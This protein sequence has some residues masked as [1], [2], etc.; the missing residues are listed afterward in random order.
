MK[1]HPASIL[2]V[3]DDEDILLTLKFYLRQYFEHIYTETNP[4]A[5]PRW[6]RKTDLDVILLD[7]NFRKGITSGEEGMAWLQKTKQLAPTVNIIMIT[8]HGEIEMAV[9]AVKHGAFDFIIKP[10]RNEK[11]RTTILA[12]LQ[13]NKSQK[14]LNQLE[15]EQKFLRKD[16]DQQWEKMIGSSEA[17]QHIHR[18]ID[19]VAGTDANI[20]ILG[21]NGT[22]KE[23]V[24]R[25]IH[26]QSDRTTQAFINV[27]LGAIQETLFES[28]LFGHIKGSFTDAKE[29]RVGRFE[30]ASGGTLFLDEIGNLSLPLQAKLLTAL[31]TR[32]I[33]RVGSNQLIYTNIRLISATNAPLYQMVKDNQFR[34]DLLYRINTVEIQLPPLR[35]RSDDIPDLIDYFM[36][37]F[38]KKYN[39]PNIKIN[40]PVY[41]KLKSYHWPGNIRELSHAVERAIIMTENGNLSIDDFL[42]R[43]SNS[44]STTTN[45][46]DT[47]NLNLEAVEK[48]TIELAL[49]AEQGNISKAAKV[50]GLTRGALYRRMEKYGL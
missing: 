14:K 2:L 36:A 25:A 47:K 1:K 17:I 50:L 12:A 4:N 16:I 8:A 42:I 21:E 18:I 3:D 37:R 6:L 32:Q 30:L 40:K 13:L 29:D 26:R 34:Q 28:E 11:L 7:M 5:I 43:K 23:L 38:S 9:E 22:G 45:V 19:K 49:K 33:R 31:Q 39:K 48:Q 27:D 46:P 15:D 20:L 10:W 41:E 35:E 24:A 44:S